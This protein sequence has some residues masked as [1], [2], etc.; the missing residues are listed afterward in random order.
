MVRGQLK[1]LETVGQILDFLGFSIQ[2]MFVEKPLTTTD[3]M[4]LTD[5]FQL[6][7]SSWESDPVKVN[8]FMVFCTSISE[9]SNSDSLRVP[10]ILSLT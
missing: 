5:I 1:S 7:P 9:P 8:L 3:L 2:M 10:H 6:M 4:L